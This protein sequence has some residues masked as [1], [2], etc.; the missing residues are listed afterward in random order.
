MKKKLF[1]LI[2]AICL[3]I[4][5]GY[6]LT[7]CGKKEE[8]IVNIDPWYLF[9]KSYDGYPAQGPVAS[10]KIQSPNPIGKIIYEEW[11]KDNTKLESAPILPGK[12]KIVICVPET[13][14]FEEYRYEK[15][16]E[17]RKA[18]S[19][20]KILASLN[21]EYDGQPIKDLTDSD[22]S[23]F[24]DVVTPVYEY[25]LYDADDTAYTTT[26]PINP[27]IY[28]LRISV[29][30]TELYTSA[31]TIKNFEIS[32]RE[33]ILTLSKQE[34]T[35]NGELID[36]KKYITTNST[37]EVTITCDNQG[38]NSHGKTLP[39]KSSYDVRISVAETEFNKAYS[40]KFYI[41]VNEKALNLP[42]NLTFSYTGGKNFTYNFTSADGICQGDGCNVRLQF[43]DSNGEYIN[44]LGTYENATLKYIEVTNTQL[45]YYSFSYYQYDEAKLKSAKYNITITGIDKSTCQNTL[46]GANSNKDIYETTSAGSPERAFKTGDVQYYFYE[47]IDNYSCAIEVSVNIKANIEIT[48]Y[49]GTKIELT[50]INNDGDVSYCRF[51]TLKRGNYLIKITALADSSQEAVQLSTKY[52]DW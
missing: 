44:M 32:K 22:I 47:Y 52:Y 24:S 42:T 25:K 35:Y 10:L 17:I 13:D 16:F 1:S 49:D 34:F 38:W 18:S 29:P 5:L 51:D 31:Y 41:K 48:Y 46:N 33:T 9:S 36:L 21:K 26:K 15:E 14:K 20:I 27:G 7:G 39:N 23:I 3:I 6:I 8:Y 28:S 37:G 50:Y 45:D 2:L 43:V 30:E 19:R 12:Y 40:D 4:P 11:Y